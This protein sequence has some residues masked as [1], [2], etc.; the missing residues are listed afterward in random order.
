MN[1]LAPPNKRE[2]D[3]ADARSEIDLRIGAAFTRFQT[4]SWQRKFE[5]LAGDSP[6][7]FGSQKKRKEKKQLASH[8]FFEGPCQFPT[9]GFVVDRWEQIQKFVPQPFW[10]I[11]MTI[12]KGT[13]AA[14]VVSRF[15]N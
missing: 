10:Y 13:F 7:S 3:A 14:R 12:L 11:K 5:G 8:S 9:L 4:L 6:I 1:T 2:A 15:R